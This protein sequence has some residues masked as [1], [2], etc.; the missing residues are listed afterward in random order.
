MPQCRRHASPV[1]GGI[2]QLLVDEPS[3]TWRAALRPQH[4]RPCGIGGLRRTR[5]RRP[6]LTLRPFVVARRD[7]RPL[8]L[9]H[10]HPRWRVRAFRKPLYGARRSRRGR[11][12]VGGRMNRS[13]LEHEMAADYGARALTAA[14][15]ARLTGSRRV[16]VTTSGRHRR[17]F[18]VT[19][20]EWKLDD[21]LARPA[22]RLRQPAGGARSSCAARD[23]RRR[24]LRIGRRSPW[25]ARA[26]STRPSADSGRGASSASRARLGRVDGARRCQ[27]GAE[28]A[29]CPVAAAQRSDERGARITAA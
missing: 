26:W 11:R 6:L 16:R 9:V 27:A 13:M 3:P 1:A 12:G 29:H 14:L 28:H 24:P 23:R 25:E 8:L 7:G 4:W 18:D 20:R 22:G 15:G 19:G 5:L 10:A 17:T 2:F 21:G